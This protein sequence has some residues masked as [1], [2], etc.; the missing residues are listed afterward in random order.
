MSNRETEISR[1]DGTV[2]SSTVPVE[3]LISALPAVANRH[4]IPRVSRLPPPLPGA[5]SQ[6]YLLDRVVIKVPRLEQTAIASLRT[7]VAVSRIMLAYGVRAARLIAFD[8]T[9]DLLPVPFAIFA[10]VP[11]RTLED[12]GRGASIVAPAWEEAGRQ[13]ALVHDVEPGNP[14]LDSLRRFEQTSE[15]DPRPWVEQLARKGAL[16]SS[17]ATSCRALT[18]H[19]AGPAREAGLCRLCHGD[20]N[21]ANVM[22]APDDPGMVTLVDWAGAG[23]LD[24]VWDFVGVPLSAVPP[25]LRG[26]RAHAPLPDDHT[27]EAR[28]LWCRLQVALRSALTAPEA[29]ESRSRCLARTIDDLVR[30]A[31]RMGVAPA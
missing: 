8:E 3:A 13:L 10:R 24:P 6:V 2:D 11:G 20:L 12:A 15:V 5:T 14:G 26:H 7:D 17:T 9:L 19:L 4:G 16:A 18:A 1:D 30:F 28:L 29:P 22:V 25:L 27:A 21:A 31:E 23:W